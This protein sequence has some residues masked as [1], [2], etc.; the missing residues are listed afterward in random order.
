MEHRQIEPIFVL[1]T[2]LALVACASRYVPSVAQAPLADPTPTPPHA[3]TDGSPSTFSLDQVGL[4]VVG[5]PGVPEDGIPCEEECQACLNG[6]DGY[7]LPYLIQ[8]VDLCC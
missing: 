5:E 2:L 7:C 1:F 4:D 3:P 8:D 6:E